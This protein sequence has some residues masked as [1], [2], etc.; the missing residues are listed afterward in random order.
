MNNE[1]L[2][3]QQLIEVS[4]GCGEGGLHDQYCR[5][6]DLVHN[7]KETESDQ[8]RRAAIALEETMPEALR[9]AYA[10]GRPNR[11]RS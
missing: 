1:E 2:T 10:E 8:R 6:G 7:G 3:L 4:G 9:A 11:S 5:K